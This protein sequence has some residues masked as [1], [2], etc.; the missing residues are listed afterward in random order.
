MFDPAPVTLWTL[1]GEH[2]VASCEVRF[3]PIGVEGRVLRNGKLLYART[4]PT[5]DET[6]EWAEDERKRHIEKGWTVAEPT[7]Q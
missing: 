3:V 7:V 6:L 2:K 5:G 1:S 4:F